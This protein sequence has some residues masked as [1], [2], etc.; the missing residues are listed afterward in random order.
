MVA[1]VTTVVAF[2]LI[3]YVKDCQ[4]IGKDPNENLLQV[5]YSL[6]LVLYLARP[7]ISSGYMTSFRLFTGILPRWPV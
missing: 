3:L 1:S 4:A 6:T 5:Q 7:V 2:V